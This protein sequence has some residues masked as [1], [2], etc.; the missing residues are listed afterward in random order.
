M[1]KSGLLGYNELEMAMRG[2]S[3][4]EGFDVLVS[5]SETELNKVLA[6]AVAADP[7][8]SV[9]SVEAFEASVAG[10]WPSTDLTTYKVNLELHQPKFA[11]AGAS[12]SP[13]IILSFELNGSLSKKN[14]D[15]SWGDTVHLPGGLTLS[16]TSLLAAVTGSLHPDSPGSRFRPA[17]PIDPSGPNAA[18]LPPQKTDATSAVV[19]YIPK[20]KGAGG[21]V[22]ISAAAGSNSDATASFMVS[23]IKAQMEDYLSSQDW[24]YYLAA[25]NNSSPG[26]PN[27][28]SLRPTSFGF[29]VSAGDPEKNIDNAVCMWI[30]VQDGSG[31]AVLG[32]GQRCNAHFSVNDIPTMPIPIGNGANA[33]IIFSHG[34]IRSLLLEAAIKKAGFTLTRDDANGDPK[35]VGMKMDFNFSSFTIKRDAVQKGDVFHV[36]PLDSRILTRYVDGFSFDMASTPATLTIHPGLSVKG[37]ATGEITW[38]GPPTRLNWNYLL[39]TP[40]PVPIKG[41]ADL[42]FSLSGRGTWED[43]ADSASTALKFRWDM[44]KHLQPVVTPETMPSDWDAF[45]NGRV[46]MIPTEL[47]N[48]VFEGFDL[49]STAELDYFLTTNLLLPGQHM[50]SPDP[51]VANSAAAQR[52]ISVPHDVLLTGV[53]TLPPTASPQPGPPAAGAPA[54][55]SFFPT[56][57]VDLSVRT[58]TPS[59]RNANGAGTEKPLADLVKTMVEYAPDSMMGPLFS[60]AASKNTEEAAEKVSRILADN[61]YGHLTGDQLSSLLGISTASENNVSHI[62]RAAHV[63]ST[64]ASDTAFDIRLFAGIYDVTAGPAQ[65]LKQKLV[66]SPYDGAIRLDNQ[67]ITPQTS[68]DST[69]KPPV[70]T[71]SWSTDKGAYRVV[72]KATATG[73]DGSFEAAFDG[74]VTLAGQTTAVPLAGRHSRDPPPPAAAFMSPHED[75]AL[76]IAGFILGLVGIV[77]FAVDIYWRRTDRKEAKAQHAGLTT[78]MD[79]MKTFM[80]ESAT[81][82]AAEVTSRISWSD[83]YQDK[84]DEAA[85]KA[86]DAKLTDP[87]LAIDLDVIDKMRDDPAHANWSALRGEGENAVKAEVNNVVKSFASAEA[88]KSISPY[89]KAG[90]ISDAETRSILNAA[91]TPVSDGVADTLLGDPGATDT[92]LDSK[93][94]ERFEAHSRV[95]RDAKVSALDAQ[96]VRLRKIQ[97]ATTNELNKRREDV[98]KIEEELDQLED[99]NDDEDEE[100]E[101]LEKERGELEDKIE[102]LVDAKR[103]AEKAVK[104]GIAE[105]KAMEKARDE[106]DGERRGKEKEARERMREKLKGE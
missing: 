95:L 100:R 83:D 46:N 12:S 32:P 82:K 79:S 15:G 27:A 97:E 18:P 14:L 103:D 28:H 44:P 41:V 13:N 16:I 67:T 81:L 69:K 52:G 86:L 17:T 74:T 76:G 64:S 2:H 102:E 4:L 37:S 50:F 5:Y 6:A 72:F 48:P 31:T 58:N 45:W 20:E 66:V 105:R 34:L 60:A 9:I 36:D 42:D 98:K 24:C 29:S 62:A 54:S 7:G 91:V 26:H 104:D 55:G 73:T 40:V 51:L 68:T 59:S 53:L 78:A 49:S 88:R 87:S 106:A 57:L 8:S 84:I 43:G 101:R 25:V 39:N 19:I 21:S 93:V 47:V 71:V 99:G 94:M 96:V 23:L 89:N 85:K 77:A 75:N 63:T 56:A 10:A 33:S 3:T 11:F 38:K 70:T 1:S 90:Y 92:Y 22:S 61:G 35:Q 30:T 65:L 80:K